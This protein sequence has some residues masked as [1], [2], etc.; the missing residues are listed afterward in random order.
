MQLG[1]ASAMRKSGLVSVRSGITSSGDSGLL[2]VSTGA[3]RSAGMLSVSA[4]TYQE[5]LPLR[6]I[7]FR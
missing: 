2:S 1:S 5:I 6:I 3:G 4:G 7:N